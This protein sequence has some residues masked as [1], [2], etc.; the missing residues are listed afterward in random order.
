MEITKRKDAAGKAFWKHAEEASKKVLS[1]PAWKRNLIVG[2]WGRGN[3][4][5]TVGEDS[6]E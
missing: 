4:M 5:E 3:V 1:W 2:S 6:N